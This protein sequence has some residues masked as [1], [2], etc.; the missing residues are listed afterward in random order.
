MGAPGKAEPCRA[1]LYN[2]GVI[3]REIRLHSPSALGSPASAAQLTPSL[4]V[5]GLAGK[6]D[7]T[8]NKCG[9]LPS[10]PVTVETSAAFPRGVF[11]RQAVCV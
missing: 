3:H 1:L 4:R 2:S 10:P 6:S 7:N 5:I 11:W 8:K 9:F